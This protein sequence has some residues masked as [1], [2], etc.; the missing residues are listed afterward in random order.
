MAL[1]GL[2]AHHRSRR[3]EDGL[4]AGADL[5]LAFEHG[6]PRIFLHLVVAERLPGL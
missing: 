4:A 6:Y 1:V 5:G 3:P 2:E